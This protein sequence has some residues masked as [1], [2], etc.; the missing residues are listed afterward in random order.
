MDSKNLKIFKTTV[1]RILLE[2][3]DYKPRVVYSPNEDYI[4]YDIVFQRKGLKHYSF[5]IWAIG[6]WSE[7]YDEENLN[8]V[9]FFGFHFNHIDKIRPSSAYI[10]EESKLEYLDSFI[11]D[12]KYILDGI[13]SNPKTYYNYS[14][15]GKISNKPA[16]KTY[17]P[18]KWFYF[19]SPKKDYT[20]NY[21][22]PNIVFFILYICSLFD[23]YI[24]SKRILC[25]RDIQKWNDHTKWYDCKFGFPITSE[26]EDVIY[27]K[28][29][30]YSEYPSKLL[31]KKAIF[32]V[33]PIIGKTDIEIKKGL[34]SGIYYEED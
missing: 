13:I 32:N 20:L 17:Y 21:L 14:R 26:D 11:R 2:L 23:K 18:D 4:G 7:H 6:K 33:Y 1:Q 30:F 29:L 12:I 34:F 31:K 3:S 15:L 5:H 10:K 27:E 19:Y 28:W 25:N 9:T 8:E 22:L 16:W 24:D